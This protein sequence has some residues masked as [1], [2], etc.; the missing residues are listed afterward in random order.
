MICEVASTPFHFIGLLQFY[1]S[2]TLLPFWPDTKMDSAEDN[3]IIEGQNGTMCT[4]KF[5]E[6]MKTYLVSL[7]KCILDESSS[8]T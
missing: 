2:L 4:S 1:I 7:T 3:D 8:V 6:R 5:Y